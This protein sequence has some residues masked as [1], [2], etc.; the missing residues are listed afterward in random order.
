MLSILTGHHLL[1]PS[2]YLSLASGLT[3]AKMR[4]RQRREEAV[5]GYGGQSFLFPTLLMDPNRYLSP[6]KLFG[7]G[8]EQCSPYIP[9]TP[10]PIF[11]SKK[12][13]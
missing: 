9:P 12:L 6:R 13:S 8:D 2:F 3:L 1:T 7:G 5:S 10:S 4:G 11:G